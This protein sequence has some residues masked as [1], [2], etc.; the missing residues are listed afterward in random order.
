MQTVSK[1]GASRETEWPSFSAPAATTC[2]RP[3]QRLA[4]SSKPLGPWYTAYIAA[5]LASNA[6][7]RAR[8]SVSLA[9]LDYPFQV[10]YFYY[11]THVFTR[12]EYPR[13]FDLVL[14]TRSLSTDLCGADVG[15]RFLTAD[16]W[17]TGL[18][19]HTEGRVRSTRTSFIFTISHAC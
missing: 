17:L 2:A 3:L 8:A 6:C 12:T 14:R 15:G 11:Q 18:H 16:V 19:G 1:K 13:G 9:Q 4:I 7:T 5:M 10:P